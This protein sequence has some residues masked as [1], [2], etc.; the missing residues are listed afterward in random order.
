MHDPAK[1]K[2]AC[3]TRRVRIAS[4]KRKG[5]TYRMLREGEGLAVGIGLA[6]RTD[7]PDR[8]EILGRLARLSGTRAS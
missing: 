4:L 2:R 7:R 5:M 3:V 1:W 8:A 6:A